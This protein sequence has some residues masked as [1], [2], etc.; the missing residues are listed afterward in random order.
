[1]QHIVCFSFSVLHFPNGKTKRQPI[2]PV[3]RTNRCLDP[4]CH[5]NYR[6]RNKGIRS[7][8][9]TRSPLKRCRC[10]ARPAAHPTFCISGCSSGV[11]FRALSPSRLTPNA[12]LSVRV[13]DGTFP[14]QR[15]YWLKY[16]AAAGRCQDGFAKNMAC[17]G[18]QAAKPSDFASLVTSPLRG[19]V[20]RW[21]S[22]RNKAPHVV[23]SWP[24]LRG[25]RGFTHSPLP[26]TLSRQS[27]I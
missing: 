7:L 17:D 15:F 27:K 24:S 4:R 1:M 22:P 14:H 11:F 12:R 23:G 10:N 18:R 20:F 3:I 25:L 16:S 2:R 13:L 6:S 21:Q 19:A 9:R 5:L 8:F 26:P